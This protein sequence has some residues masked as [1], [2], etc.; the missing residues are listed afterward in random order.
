MRG[1]RERVIVLQ[2]KYRKVLRWFREDPISWSNPSFFSFPFCNHEF[3]VLRY[4][5]HHAAL[6][7]ERTKPIRHKT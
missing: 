5:K 1:E 3:I 7:M 4:K 6:A 2:L